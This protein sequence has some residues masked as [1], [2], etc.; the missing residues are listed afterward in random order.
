[1]MSSAILKIF[2]VVLICVA[3]GSVIKLV[4][5]EMAFA[6]RI[7]GLL[8]A[9]GMIILSSDV[10]LRDVSDALDAGSFSEYAELIL[11]S[12]G[13]AV[14]THVAAAVCRDCGEGGLAGAVELAGKIEILL[15]SL[16]MIER[17][18]KYTAE[19]AAIG[20]G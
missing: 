5:G 14:L 7:A 3:V 15:L 1:M 2:A 16:P 4:R 10:L 19:I 18:L 6:V 9:F 17:L 8:V 11:K 12:L 13:I 20:S